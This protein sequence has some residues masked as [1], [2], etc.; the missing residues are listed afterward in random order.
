MT[1]EEL[2]NK[3]EKVGI[4][5]QWVNP[6]KYGFSRTYEFVINEQIVQIEWY[7]NYLLL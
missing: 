7:T 3:L 4:N 1:Q 2:V 6:D 5:G